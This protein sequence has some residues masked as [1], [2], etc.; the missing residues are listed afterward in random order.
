M[1][2]KIYENL[3]QIVTQLLSFFKAVGSGTSTI[4]RPKKITEIDAL[5]FALYQHASTRAT[6]KSVYDD[7]KDTLACSYKTFVVSVN[8]VAILSLR[9]LALLMQ[10]NKQG[11]HIVK[12]TDA[13]DIPVCLKKN[14]DHHKTM[15]GLVGLGRSTKGWY[16][17]LK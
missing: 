12:Y 16:Y 1:I 15:D 9:I 4:G 17:G 11:S 5:A 13:T 6:K 8:E 3:K 14:M 10:F 2:P 7:F